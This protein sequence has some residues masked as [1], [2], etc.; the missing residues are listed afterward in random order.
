M[1]GPEPKTKDERL[2][3]KKTVILWSQRRGSTIPV[4]YGCCGTVRM[5][6]QTKL[7]RIRQ[8]GNASCAHCAHLGGRR[9]WNGGR[10]LT[11]QGY[12]HLHISLVPRAHQWLIADETIYNGI[13]IPEHRYVMARKLGRQLTKGE[14]AHHKNGKKND[15][16]PSNLELRRRYHGTGYTHVECSNCGHLVDITI[17]KAVRA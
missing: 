6:A 7:Y 15:N 11:S 12:V 1:P 16:R 5:M 10:I 3:D 14:S 4:K 2:S 9:R 13:Y 8:R 17:G